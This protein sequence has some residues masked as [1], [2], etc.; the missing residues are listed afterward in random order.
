MADDRIF[1][2]FPDAKL[3][4]ANLFA[5]SLS[6]RLRNV[7]PSVQIEL[8]KRRAGSMDCGST[9]ALVLG[10]AA[11]TEMAK[12]IAQWIARHK[13]KVQFTTNT[14]TL[15]VSDADPESVAKIIQA[16]SSHK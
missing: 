16:L 7:D 6:N 15:I 1:L 8:V 2:S 3:S 14:E 12:G 9:V 11:A 5:A 13:T 10:T 4:A